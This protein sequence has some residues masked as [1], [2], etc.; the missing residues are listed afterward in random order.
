MA[1]AREAPEQE[2]QAPKARGGGSGG[3]GAE[4]GPPPAMSRMDK[5]RADMN[6]KVARPAGDVDAPELRKDAA[7]HEVAA[8]MKEAPPKNDS[9]FDFLQYWEARG[10]DGVDP[11]GKVVVL[12]R[13]AYI[14]LLTRLYAGKDTTS[15]QT[16][17]NFSA[18]KQVLSDMRAGTLFP[19]LRG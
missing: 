10:T 17:R 1:K 5:I 16:E 9:K 11:S 14:R 8:Y 6:K 7:L 2:R 3:T 18:L 12:A 19:D 15:C 13:W 4:A